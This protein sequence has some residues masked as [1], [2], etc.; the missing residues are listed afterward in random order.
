MHEGTTFV[1][2][3]PRIA[4]LDL[5]LAEAQ[6]L[7]KPLQD[8]CWLCWWNRARVGGS[9]VLRE[10]DRGVSHGLGF[11]RLEETLLMGLTRGE[12]FPRSRPYSHITFDG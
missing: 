1:Q 3:C 9:L 10:R 5:T 7:R 6:Q 2:D 4:H 11:S 8:H 12:T